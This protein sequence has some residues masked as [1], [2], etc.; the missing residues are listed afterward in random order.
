MVNDKVRDKFE[1]ACK[2]AKTLKNPDNATLGYLYGHYKQATAGDCNAPSPS[3]WDI[4]SKAKYQ[5][6]S[7]L[8]GMSEE[9]AMVN[10]TKKVR[11]LKKAE[12]H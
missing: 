7:E 12:E 8:R 3:I 10:Y 4:T 5:A 9:V 2:D 1:G 11:A 6:W